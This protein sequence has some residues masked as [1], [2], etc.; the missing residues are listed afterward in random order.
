MKPKLILTIF[1]FAIIPSLANAQ[2][3]SYIKNRLTFDGL[4]TQ[5]QYW[6][7][8]ENRNG[9]SFSA[10]YGTAKCLETGIK[11]IYEFEENHFVG[12]Q[13]RFHI[14]PFFVKT[15]NKFFRLDAYVF[16]NTGVELGR[17]RDIHWQTDPNDVI[18]RIYKEGVLK[19][20]YLNFGVGAAFNIFKRLAVRFEYKCDFRLKKS[21]PASM[22]YMNKYSMPVKKYYFGY[23]QN[24]FNVGLSLK[25]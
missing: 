17:V 13:N 9:L 15:N 3:S 8:A 6:G 12:I 19:S 11:Y 4:Y 2:K 1:I 23:A 24:G 5:M 25:F 20:L 18:D 21:S 10:N 7:Y 16:N 14:L 22:Y